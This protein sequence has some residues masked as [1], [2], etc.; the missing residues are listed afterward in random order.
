[1]NLSVYLPSKLSSQLSLIAQQKHKSKNA[2]VKEALE[3]WLTHHHPRSS[4]PPHFFDFE[5]V[6]DAPDFSI[7]R[8]EL[9]PPKEDIF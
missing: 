3:E 7:Y 9:A 6:E 8:N 4:W 5:P 1:M 2:I